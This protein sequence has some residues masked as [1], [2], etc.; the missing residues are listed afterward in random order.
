MDAPKR[1]LE[2]QSEW[3]QT[4]DTNRRTEIWQEML[5][6]HADQQFAIGILSGAPQPVVVS[7]RLRNVPQVWHR[8]V[9]RDPPCSL[10]PWAYPLEPR[11]PRAGAQRH[12]A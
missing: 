5:A 1:L 6:I 4:Q 7:E 9:S 3:R 11:R 12:T 10:A 2:L 8:Q